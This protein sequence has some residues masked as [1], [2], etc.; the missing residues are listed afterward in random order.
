[1]ENMRASPL[2]YVSMGTPVERGGPY[3]PYIH[4][5]FL[6]PPARF[7]SFHHRPIPILP[8]TSSPV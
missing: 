8:S 5:V 6:T 3:P 1:M 2:E 4:P 7:Y